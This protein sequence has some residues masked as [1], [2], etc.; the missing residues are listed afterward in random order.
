MAF[1]SLPATTNS[2][3]IQVERHFA[4][5]LLMYRY[6]GAPP[7]PEEQ[8]DLRRELIARGQLTAETRAVMDLRALDG[9]PSDEEMARTIKLAMENHAWP[10]RR[11]YVVLPWMHLRLLQAIEA[12][13]GAAITMAAFMDERAAVEW[14]EALE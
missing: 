2:M 11:A 3:P 7:S 9:L 1:V 4:P 6:V 12:Q 10:R 8:A 5:G 14:V 13:A